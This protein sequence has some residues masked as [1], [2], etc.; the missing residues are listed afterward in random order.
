MQGQHPGLQLY[1]VAGFQDR[2]VLRWDLHVPG[3]GHHD[4]FQLVLFLQR[5]KRVQD[6]RMDAAGLRSGTV[7]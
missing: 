7:L 4:Q 3:G 2:Y 6:L 5:W 1:P